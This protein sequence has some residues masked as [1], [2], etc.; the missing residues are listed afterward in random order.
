MP[1]PPSPS[2]IDSQYHVASTYT[3]LIPVLKRVPS[4]NV[5]ADSVRLEA[6]MSEV[7][8]W[9]VVLQQGIKD[10]EERRQKRLAM[11][12]DGDSK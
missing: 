8:R 2:A 6:L 7:D 3:S 9:L 1:R 11:G 4:S 10:L 12:S 5:S